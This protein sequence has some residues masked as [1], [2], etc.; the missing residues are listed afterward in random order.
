MV[1]FGGAKQG[2]WM[3]FVFLGGEMQIKGFW[4]V[5]DCFFLFLDALSFSGC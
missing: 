2:V 3:V 4:I 5:L 1:S